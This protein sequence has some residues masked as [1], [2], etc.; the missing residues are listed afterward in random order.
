[1][2]PTVTYRRNESVAVPICPS[3]DVISAPT[4]IGRRFPDS[5]LTS[6]LRHSAW[7]RPHADWHDASTDYGADEHRPMTQWQVMADETFDAAFAPARLQS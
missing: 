1:M 7:K 3:A 6:P 4:T 2:S 5:F